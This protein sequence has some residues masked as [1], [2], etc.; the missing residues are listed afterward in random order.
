MRKGLFFCNEASKTKR[1][2]KLDPNKR[3]SSETT[4]RQFDRLEAGVLGL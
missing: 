1:L 2:E 3:Y 4:A